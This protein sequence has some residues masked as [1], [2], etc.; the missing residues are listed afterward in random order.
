MEQNKDRK[1]VKR[2]YEKP[3]LRVV[4][5]SGGIQTLAIGCKFRFGTIQAIG[6]APCIANRCSA[7]GS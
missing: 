5:I 3:V 6:S 4:D 2:A 7:P 1:K